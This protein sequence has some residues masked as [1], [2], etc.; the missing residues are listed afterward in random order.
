MRILLRV[1]RKLPHPGIEK[2]PDA[3]PRHLQVKAAGDVA[4]VVGH[5]KDPAA[6]LLLQGNAVLLE[7]AIHNALQKHRVV[8]CGA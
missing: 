6:P 2:H 7:K 5:G 3:K 8:L 1:H 4:G